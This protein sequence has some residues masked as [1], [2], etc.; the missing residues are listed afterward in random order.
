MNEKRKAL[1]Q[2][3]AALGGLILLIIIFSF[4]SDSFSQ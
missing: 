2:K 3:L 1:L 4:T